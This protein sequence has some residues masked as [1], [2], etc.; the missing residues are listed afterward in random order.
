ML[1][2]SSECTVKHSHEA[3]LVLVEQLLLEEFPHLYSNIA[4]QVE[5]YTRAAISESHLP[6]VLS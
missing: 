4:T 2:V 5:E 6:L 3:G 1:A